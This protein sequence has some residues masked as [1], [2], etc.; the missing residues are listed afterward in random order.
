MTRGVAAS[1]A[2]AAIALVGG[3]VFGWFPLVRLPALLL[4]VLAAAFVIAR[5]WRWSPR[6]IE[7]LAAWTPSPRTVW[8]ATFVTAAVLAWIVLTR[9]R[10]GDINAVDFTVY[11]DRPLYQTAQG[12]PLFVETADLPDFSHRSQFAVHAY[13]ILL[14]LA[15]LYRIAA[16]PYW[17]LALSIAAVALGALHAFRIVRRLSGVGLVA[18]AAAFAFVLNANTAR[19]LLYGFHPEVLYAWLIPAAIDAAIHRRRWWFLAAV[20]AAAAVKEDAIL[21]L[22]AMSV[23]LALAGRVA[24]DDRWLCLAAPPAIALA[25]LAAYY[26]WVLPIFAFSSNPVY[27][28]FWIDYGPTPARAAIGMLSRPLDVARSV[29]G[30]GF[31]RVLLPHALL[32]LIGWRWIAGIVP[33]VVLY[34]ASSNSQV[35]DFGI[36][37]SM[38]T[39]PFLTLGS[40]FGALVVARA[41]LAREAAAR[42]AAASVVFLAALLVYGDR[43]GY[44][45][46]PWRSEVAAT[47]RVIATLASEPVVLVQSALYPHA[48]YDGRLVLLTRETLADPNYSGAITLL[49]PA[50][51]AYPFEKGDLDALAQRGQPVPG[52]AGI[53]LVRRP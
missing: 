52:S 6:D 2:V 30:S 33:L 15:P 45:L 8:I 40:A 29:A 50:L 42:V 31:L 34:G 46:R 22:F 24:R 51:N 53:I 9:F 47:P 36:Y 3:P 10:S 26:A 49:A 43:A 13:Y 28:G 16:T 5:P 14:L 18:A 20:L 4:P 35:R 23:T 39:V 25:N 17:L 19:T 12:R 44:S 21:P 7:G 1:A 41:L 32:P 27:A 48:G 11:F 37:Y 38:V